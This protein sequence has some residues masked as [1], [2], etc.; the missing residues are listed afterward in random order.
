MRT[1]PYIKLVIA[2]LLVLRC[3]STPH[4]QNDSPITAYLR[5]HAETPVNYVMSKATSHR[6]T[7]IGEGHWLKQDVTLVAALIPL[8]QKADL[9]LAAEFFPA[10]E[11]ARIDALITA[12]KWNEQE[13]NAIMRAAAWPYQEYRDLLRTAWSANQGAKRTIKILALSPPL[14]WRKVLLPRGE[15]YES[16]MADLVSKHLKEARRNLVVY[17]GMHHAFTR[18]YQAELDKDARARAYMDRMGNILSRRLGEQ[19]FLITLHKP[20]WC[21]NLE[22]RSYCLPFG[23]RIDCEATEVGR[24]LGFDVVGSPWAEMRFDRADYYAYGHVALRFVDYT[25]G[26]I[27]SGP[28]ESFRPVTIIPLSEYAPDGQTREQLTH[29]NPF[30][31]E[32]N[33]TAK[34]LEEIWAQ[35]TAA[36][37]DLLSRRNWKNLVG[38]Q[39]R[40]P[41]P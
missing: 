22:P 3:F 6:V 28:L 24:P 13:A 41:K 23:G 18:Y 30:N 32:V 1:T 20:T 11:Q 25:D 21:G 19:V 27:W 37:Q 39:A 15:T 38:W 29:E 36:N 17:C 14:D 12:A 40:C 7:I 10:A 35:Q 34:R 31:D 5:E 33:V 8:L 16:F 9:D 26:Y 2:A 4:A